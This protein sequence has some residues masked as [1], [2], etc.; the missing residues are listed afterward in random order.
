MAN[1]MPRG[2]GGWK[3]VRGL[4]QHLL[5]PCSFLIYAQDFAELY[6]RDTEAY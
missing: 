5:D 6:G 3:P 2:D 4:R 1:W